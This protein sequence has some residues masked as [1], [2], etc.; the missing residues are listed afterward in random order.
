MKRIAISALA[1]CFMTAFAPQVQA[2]S[3]LKGLASK[4]KTKMTEKIVPGKKATETPATKTAAPSTKTT[5]TPESYGKGDAVDIDFYQNYV[6]LLG[7]PERYHNQPSNFALAPEDIV[8]KKPF[9]SISEAVSALPAFPTTAQIV[10]QD[11]AAA[12]TWHTYHATVNQL[13]GKTATNI[14]A[15]QLSAPSKLKKSQSKVTDAQR[16][17]MNASA[18]QI[19]QL[20][21]KY[22]IDP[23][24]MSDKEMEAFVMKCI[25]N[26]ELKL[27]NAGVLDSNCDEKQEAIIDQIDA[28]LGAFDEEMLALNK[29]N[30]EGGLFTGKNVIALYEEMQKAWLSSDACKQVY[31]IEKDIDVRKQEYFKTHPS[32]GPN[33][34]DVP[35]PSFW[36]EGRKKQNEIIRKFNTANAERWGKEAKSSLDPIVQCCQKLATIDAELESAFSDKEEPMY[37]MLKSRIHS[38]F[39]GLVLSLQ[40]VMSSVDE[41]PFVLTVAES[42]GG[43]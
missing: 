36:V 11:K 2:Q 25:A 39:A 27:P 23:E 37:V 1:L 16:A 30:I 6:E 18:A 34:E 5:V 15:A 3:M 12:N 13:I 19:F 43:Q 14:T 17:Q 26:G 9:A 21:Q 22:N 35:N 32:I 4:A 38:H 31:D 28:K 8:V 20:M 42:E 40:T 41:L 24:K 10:S 33:G 29:N 7:A